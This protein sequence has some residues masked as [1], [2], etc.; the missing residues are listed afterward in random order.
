VVA[1]Q[2]D[3]DGLLEEYKE[4][5]TN[6]KILELAEGNLTKSEMFERLRGQVYFETWL[7]RVFSFLV[8]WVALMMVAE[9]IQHFSC[10][11]PCVETL[12]AGPVC[13]VAFF[14]AVCWFG[15][16]L[17]LAWIS[18]RP[19]YAIPAI[20]ILFLIF[21]IECCGLMKL[22]ERV[23]DDGDDDKDKDG[24]VEEGGKGKDVA[25]KTGKDKMVI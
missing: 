12:V 14:L 23:T 2:K 22:I 15:V 20:C 7:V 9:P 17:S 25:R 4:P 13:C 5:D 18:V 1:Q 24:D 11:C 10:C 21:L 19:N 16:W 6:M 3:G 8:I